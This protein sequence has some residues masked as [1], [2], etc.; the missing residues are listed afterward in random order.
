MHSNLAKKWQEFPGARSAAKRGQFLFS[1]TGETHG[2]TNK[3]IGHLS[4][5]AIWSLWPNHSALKGPIHHPLTG[6]VVPD[7]VSIP[8]DSAETL[9]SSLQLLQHGVAHWRIVNDAVQSNSTMLVRY[10]FSRKEHGH[11][12]TSYCDFVDLP[13]H[14]Q[15]QRTLL[16]QSDESKL[17]TQV[18][19]HNHYHNYSSIVV[20]SILVYTVVW[21][22]FEISC[23]AAKISTTFDIF[24]TLLSGN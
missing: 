1:I 10:T 13:A 7:W 2:V 6:C 24:Q 17:L 18:W 20:L 9:T 23:T 19:N 16:S 5:K 22:L 4:S 14:I 15:V 11:T 21:L 12:Y 3:C 8:I